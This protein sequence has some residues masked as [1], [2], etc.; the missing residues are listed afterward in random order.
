VRRLTLLL[1]SACLSFGLAA[2]ASDNG[3]KLSPLN[4]KILSFCKKSVGKKVGDGQCADLAYLALMQSGAESPDDFKDNPLPGD[5]VWG[6]LIYGHK[7]DGSKHMETGDRKAV[8]PGDIIQ[9][10]DVLIE[11]Q[12]ESQ[13]YITKETIDA[14]HHTAVVA[15]VSADGM[16]YQVIEQNAN[17]VPTV[18][19]GSLHLDDMKKG[20]ILVYRAK[21]DPDADDGSAPRSG[22][23]LGDSDRRSKTAKTSARHYRY[24]HSSRK[25]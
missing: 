1:A 15:S 2:H 4:Q 18:T 12:E 19:N 9:M 23:L 11:H 22:Q 24:H 3:A 8:R 21:S 25:G 16:T 6:D 17:D 13:E 10:R 7:L 20:Y 5:Y 14:D